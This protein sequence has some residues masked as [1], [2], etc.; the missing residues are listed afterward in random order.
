MCERETSIG[1]LPHAHNWGPGLQHMAGCEHCIRI[2]MPTFHELTLEEVDL[3]MASVYLGKGKI[4]LPY[5]QR[6]NTSRKWNT[7]Y[8]SDK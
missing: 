3:G 1:C 7:L 4:F 5:V 2:T 6:P 8:A